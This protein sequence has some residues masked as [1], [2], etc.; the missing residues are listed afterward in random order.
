[1]RED[2][3]R[4]RV[5]ASLLPDGE[6][7]LLE[8]ARHDEHAA[9]CD[10]CRAYGSELAAITARIR[11]APPQEPLASIALEMPLPLKAQNRRRRPGAHV[12]G[13][14]AVTVLIGS[15]LDD[16]GSREPG[17]PTYEA[18]YF[19]SIDYE[20]DLLRAVRRPPGVRGVSKAV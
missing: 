9:R 7:T 6:L 20:R 16:S 8:A 3:E 5:T 13:V 14:L 17:Q 10:D 12:A 2:C 11:S 15:G 4:F 1:M 19:E 18:A